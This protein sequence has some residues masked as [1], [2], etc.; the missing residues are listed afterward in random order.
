MQYIVTVEA[1]G[2]LNSEETGGTHEISETNLWI[3]FYKFTYSQRQGQGSICRESQPTF[4]SNTAL[5][6]IGNF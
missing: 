5:R 6:I 1:C 4:E 2:S 3:W